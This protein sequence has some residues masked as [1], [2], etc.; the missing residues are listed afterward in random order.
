MLKRIVTAT[1][2]VCWLTAAAAAQ[3]A[4]AQ[5]IVFEAEPNVAPLDP[6]FPQIASV[7]PDGSGLRNL[8]RTQLVDTS[9]AWSPDRSQVAFVRRLGDGA[10]SHT[11]WLGI[12]VMNADGSDQHVVIQSTIAKATDVAWSPNGS[13]LAITFRDQTH[14][15]GLYVTDTN[16]TILRSLGP[17]LRPDWSPDGSRIAFEDSS[18]GSVEASLYTIAA[19]GSDRQ[20]LTNHVGAGDGPLWSPDGQHLLWVGHCG[21][22]ADPAGGI[23]VMDADGSD[24]RRL[25]TNRL[26]GG[27]YRADWSPDGTEIAFTGDLGPDFPEEQRYGLFK[28]STSG[29]LEQRLVPETV[30]GGQ[31]DWSAFGDPQ[32]PDVTDPSI[33]IDSPL[34]GATFARGAHVTA[35]Y[36]CHDELGGSGVN[37]CVGDV[38]DGA[39]LDTSTLGAHL[40]TVQ[41]TDDVGNVAVAEA[42]YTVADQTAPTVTLTTP[43][44]GASYRLLATVK[45][46]Y[47]CGDEPGGSGLVSCIGT[48][49]SGSSLPTGLA[50]LGTHTFSVTATDAAGNHTTVAHTYRVTLLGF[51]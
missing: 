40:L 41:A 47:G 37:T 17:G 49:P 2:V 45:A 1:V 8:S 16:G 51:L 46:Q 29:G 30:T 50:A 20:Q 14:P 31:V 5:R 27:A 25:Y 18:P 21:C 22:D 38:A 10:Q 48:Q 11:D 3:P 4:V 9:P 26:G 35:A 13:E 12:V 44:E 6:V 23:S 43:P 32:P 42:H 34:D 28:I 7:R 24:R 15:Q 19:D 33:A 39:P 36:A